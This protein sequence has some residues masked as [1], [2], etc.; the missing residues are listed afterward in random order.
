MLGSVVICPALADDA[1]AIE[2]LLDAAFGA[3]RRRRTAYRLRAGSAMLAGPSLVARDGGSLAGS[4]QCWPLQLLSARGVVPLTLLGPLAVAPERQGAGVGKA[5]LAAALGE[6]DAAG[7]PPVLLIGDEDY[8]A[9]FGF[10]A[11]ATAGWLLPGPVD[12]ARVLL[13]GSGL[14]RFGV[15]QPGASALPRAA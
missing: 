3:D 8:Y 6:I 2:T 14:P 15:L 5:L 7:L 10:A 9:P 11:A 4:V 1:P 12:P 13:R